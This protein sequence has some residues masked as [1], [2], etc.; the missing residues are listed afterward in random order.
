MT[1]NSNKIEGVLF[2]MDGTVL[3]SEHLFD[4]A[5]I[6]LLKKFKIDVSRSELLEFKGMSYKDFY[7]CFMNKFNLNQDVDYLRNMLRNFL[8]KTMETELKFIDGFENFFKTRIINK[9]FKIGLVTNTTRLSYRKIQ[10]CI[11]IDDYFDYVLTVN[12]VPKPKPSPAPYLHAMQN[13]KLNY[14]ETIILEDSKTGLISAKNSNA[15]VIGLT[16]SLNSNEIKEIDKNINVCKSYK[17]VDE[18][19]K[20]I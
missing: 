19:F 6:K 13:L 8:H 17:E 3:D 10:T 18:H 1:S 15:Q 9:G 11:N 5:Q 7:P 2:D 14:F 20:H 12:E 4:K 16:T